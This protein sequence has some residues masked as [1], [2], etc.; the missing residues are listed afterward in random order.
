[1][2]LYFQHDITR[3]V[4]YPRALDND[5]HVVRYGTCSFSTRFAPLVVVG[6]REFFF[7]TIAF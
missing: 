4:V 6:P 3:E 5:W 2:M 7:A 1:M